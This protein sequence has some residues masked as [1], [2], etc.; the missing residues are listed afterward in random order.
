MEHLLDHVQGNSFFGLGA[1]GRIS[2]RFKAVVQRN[3]GSAQG[4]IKVC[5]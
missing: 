2:L 4:L 5:A 1:I 3:A